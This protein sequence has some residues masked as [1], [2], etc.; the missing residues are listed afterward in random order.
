ME[1]LGQ[2]S[3]HPDYGCPC[4]WC[5]LE[6]SVEEARVETEEFLV[7]SSLAPLVIRLVAGVVRLGGI[8][9]PGGLE[10]IEQ[11]GEEVTSGIFASV[12]I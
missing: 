2:D 1:L 4:T 10:M 9:R 12:R 5:L 8:L 3:S 11:F 7:V 6:I